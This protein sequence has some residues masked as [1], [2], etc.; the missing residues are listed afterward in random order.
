MTA[1]GD[2]P[3]AQAHLEPF[4]GA[5]ETLVVVV[6]LALLA[7]YAPGCLGGRGGKSEE[8]KSCILD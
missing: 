6:H 5:P 7:N 4:V 1:T 3:L 2:S 8:R